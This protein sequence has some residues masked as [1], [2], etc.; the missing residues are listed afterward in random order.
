MVGININVR[1]T[2]VAGKCFIK[3]DSL[4]CKKLNLHLKYIFIFYYIKRNLLVLDGVTITRRDPNLI[5]RLIDK[6]DLSH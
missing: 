2:K 1:F 4:L 6:R 3:N 5:V